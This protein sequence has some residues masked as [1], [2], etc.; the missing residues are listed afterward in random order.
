MRRFMPWVSA[1]V[2]ACLLAAQKPKPEEITTT[3]INLVNKYGDVRAIMSCDTLADDPVIVI[4]DAKGKF[5][6][7]VSL[8]GLIKPPSE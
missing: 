5:S 3:R 4:Y 7:R 6:G 8:A 1:V 2:L